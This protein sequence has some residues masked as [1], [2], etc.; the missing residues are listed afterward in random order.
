MAEFPI[1]DETRLFMDSSGSNASASRQN[2]EGHE[3]PTDIHKKTEPMKMPISSIALCDSPSKG[4]I[5]PNT[6]MTAAAANSL[7][8]S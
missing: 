1:D 7:S 3:I 6:A 4:V 5:N 8:A 2:R